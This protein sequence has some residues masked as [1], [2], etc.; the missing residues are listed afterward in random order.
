MC[1]KGVKRKTEMDII[2]HLAVCG[3]SDWQ[4]VNRLLVGGF[5]TGQQAQ[6]S[7]YTSSLLLSSDSPSRV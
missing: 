7:M 4:R 6:R 2:T 1:H 5:V 3:S